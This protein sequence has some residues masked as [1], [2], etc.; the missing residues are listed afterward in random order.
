MLQQ[1]IANAIESAYRYVK[2]HLYCEK[3]HLLYDHRLGDWSKLPTREE[4]ERAFPNPCGYGTGMEDSII[5]GAGMIDALLQR[6]REQ[7]SE[8][9]RAFLHE[10]LDGLLLTAEAGKDGFLPRSRIPSDGISHYPDSSR[11]QYTLFL[12]A[13]WRLNA[14]RAVNEGELSRIRCAVVRIAERAIRNVTP[15]NGYDLLREDGGRS[16]VTTM[17]GE[18]GNHEMPRLPMLYL[19]AYDLSGEEAYLTRY[20]A[21]REEMLRGL[22]PMGHYWAAY[23]VAQ[24]QMSLAVIRALDPDPAFRRKIHTVMCHVANFCTQSLPEYREKLVRKRD[25]RGEYPS[26]RDLAC[27]PRKG[28]ADGGLPNLA[29]VREGFDVFYN[30]QDAANLLFTVALAGE[31]S[32]APLA[33]MQEVLLQLDFE[34]H[35]TGAPIQFLQ[36][37]YTWRRA[38]QT[39]SC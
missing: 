25:F 5:N 28:V 15:E 27:V 35:M 37:Y 2:T 38:Y 23:C 1:Q 14:E 26:F 30:L 18:I 6:L 39:R 20:M 29:P 9:D 16:L 24:M 36:A 31:D 12:Y 3:T 11:D 22:L 10:L 34:K 8:Q 32:A 13:M 33:W 4:T 7:P 17:W 21:L 19:L